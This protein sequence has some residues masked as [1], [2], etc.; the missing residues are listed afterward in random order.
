MD[1]L[2][3]DILLGPCLAI[4]TCNWEERFRGDQFKKTL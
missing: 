3:L 1:D 4:V 2:E